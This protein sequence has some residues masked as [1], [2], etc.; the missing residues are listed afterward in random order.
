[1]LVT[2]LDS[3]SDAVDSLVGLD[4]G[5]ALEGGLGSLVLLLEEIIV[6][7]LTN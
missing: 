6:S 2:A 3:T 4:V 1:M 5:K 7:V